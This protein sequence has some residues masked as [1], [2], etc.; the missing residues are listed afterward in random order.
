[1]TEEE[2]LDRFN[3][4][5]VEF[6]HLKSQFDQLL[7]SI[8]AFSQTDIRLQIFE[9][10]IDSFKVDIE[11]I[12]TTT[13]SNSTTLV[14]LEKKVTKLDSTVNEGKPIGDPFDP[15]IHDYDNTPPA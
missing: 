15:T 4:I 1:M 6:I 5:N 3:K 9:S 11:S 10:K 2:L 12:K 7:N 8:S 13:E 14:E